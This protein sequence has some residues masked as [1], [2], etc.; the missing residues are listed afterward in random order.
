MNR[1]KLYLDSLERDE[2]TVAEAEE[3]AKHCSDCSFDKKFDDRIQFVLNNLAEPEYPDNL[4]EILVNTYKDKDS[5]NI[6]EQN[7]LEKLSMF[8]LKPIEIIAPIACVIMLICMVNLN[9]NSN[10]EELEK[11]SAKFASANVEKTFVPIN[12]EGLEKVSPEEVKEFLAKL[13]EFNKQH[14][15]NKRIHNNNLDIRLVT[16]R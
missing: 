9:S 3:H 7:F 2:K 5:S 12:K 4:H 15:E 10:T 14:P 16:D 8:L 13:D 6:E 11:K 1:C